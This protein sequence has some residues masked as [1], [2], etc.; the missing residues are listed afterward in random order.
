MS[1]MKMVLGMFVITA[2]MPIG[3]ASAAETARNGATVRGGLQRAESSASTSY[4]QPGFVIGTNLPKPSTME[5]EFLEGILY[6]CQKY[7][8]GKGFQSLSACIAFYDQ[9]E[10]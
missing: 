7:Y 9:S 3:G 2:L 4:L 5:A 6:G 8:Q 10:P 1:A